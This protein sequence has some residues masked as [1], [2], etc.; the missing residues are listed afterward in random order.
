MTPL[1]AQ[2]LHAVEAEAG[3]VALRLGGGQLGL[4]LAGVQLDQHVPLAHRAAGLEADAGRRCR[5]SP[6]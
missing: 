6:R 2:A 1:V 5:A 3:E 4:L